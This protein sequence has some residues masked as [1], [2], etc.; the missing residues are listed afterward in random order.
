MDIDQNLIAQF[1]V[2]IQSYTHQLLIL[3]QIETVPAPIVDMNKQTDSYRHLQIDRPYTALNSETYISIRQQELWTCKKIGY[4]FYYKEL[5]WV[6]HKSKCSC[7]SAIFFNLGPDIIKE[8]CKFAYY[9]NKTNI[10]PMVPDRG[11]EINLVN[12]P[13]DKHNICNINNDIS[14]KIPS[15]P[16]VL[17]N[18]SVLCNCG[19]EAE[20]NFLL[21]SL[22]A[23]HHV[24]SKL[25]M[26]FMGN[27]TFVNYLNSLDNLIDSLKVPLL[28][29]K[30][31]YKQI[32]PISL[33]TPEYDSKLWMVPD[34][35]EKEI[36]WFMGKTYLYRIRIV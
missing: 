33:P 31:T 28:L 18:G 16:Y 27:T 23:C 21:E 30:T 11:N 12:K 26:Y 7:E 19:I 32:L 8:N 17:V 14:I 24:K 3:Y 29:N 4:K 35:A 34:T 25:V 36:F 10:T 20:N 9:F 22:A 15:H 2:V 1:P 5:F 13:G 6:K